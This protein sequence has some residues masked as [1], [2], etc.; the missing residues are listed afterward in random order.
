[1]CRRILQIRPHLFFLMLSSE[2][3]ILTS[4]YDDHYLPT[5]L[6]VGRG[7]YTYVYSRDSMVY[8]LPFPPLEILYETLFSSLPN[9]VFTF[10]GSSI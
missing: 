4:S 8:H 3:G 5:I 7:L 1:M 10:V 6:K 2:S 9:L